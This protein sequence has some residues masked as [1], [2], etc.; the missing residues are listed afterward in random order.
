MKLL[1]TVLVAALA[2]FLFT[3][4]NA[5]NTTLEEPS[6]VHDGINWGGENDLANSL[7][8]A[9]I[10]HSMNIE[11]QKAY[12][13]FEKAVELDS[14]LFA[15]HTALALLSR[16][17]KR[18]HHK[19]MANKFV[20]GENETSKLFVSLLDIENDSTAADKRRAVWAKMHDLSNG[21]F[22]HFRYALTRADSLEVI[23]ELDKLEA[24]L[25]EQGWN[26]AHVYNV[27]GY[28]YQLTGD[29]ERGTREIEKYMELYPEGYNPLD[30]RAEFYL[31]AGDTTKA[32]EYYEKALNRF[33]YSI[34]A[35]N[36]LDELK[37]AD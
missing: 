10:D 12:V 26:T 24:F 34:S 9:G 20:A 27:R 19:M 23:A 33:R 14:S 28:M 25:T 32:I 29:L 31:F 6:A 11:Q 2:L 21:P 1:S 15:S 4:Q 30:S 35:R 7:A 13:L 18:D 17:E 3:C 5:D 16:G 36:A 37:K 8:F 22:I